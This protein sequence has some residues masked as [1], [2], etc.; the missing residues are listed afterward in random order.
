[1]KLPVA[2]LELELVADE[3]ALDAV[4]EFEGLPIE[5]SPL[6]TL[7]I[8]FNSEFIIVFNYLKRLFTQFRRI[9]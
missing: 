9:N 4:V 8:L 2:A 6:K 7:S 3:P 1:M 5:I